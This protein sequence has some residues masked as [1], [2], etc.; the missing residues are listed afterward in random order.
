MVDV[1]YG[2]YFVY[3]Y[4]YCLYCSGDD[5][6]A[7]ECEGGGVPMLCGVLLP[8]PH[9]LAPVRTLLLTN[10]C[11]VY[12]KHE[13]FTVSHSV[14]YNIFFLKFVFVFRCLKPIRLS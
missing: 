5:G 1:Y 11:R 10:Y 6:V 12:I 3:T 8:L 4:I 13:I 9:T 14:S 2:I 7:S